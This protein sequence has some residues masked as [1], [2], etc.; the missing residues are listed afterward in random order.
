LIVAGTKD[1]DL[2][3]LS[4]YSNY[5]THKIS[6]APFSI[7]NVFYFGL[8]YMTKQSHDWPKTLELFLIK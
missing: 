8:E 4:D 6:M 7:E 1:G 3:K 5:I 2:E